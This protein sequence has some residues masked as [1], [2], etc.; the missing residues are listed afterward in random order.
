MCVCVISYQIIDQYAVYQKLMSYTD[1]SLGLVIFQACQISSQ[2]SEGYR[3]TSKCFLSFLFLLLLSP[4]IGTPVKDRFQR[5]LSSCKILV[6]S[7]SNQKIPGIDI[8]FMLEAFN[9][10]NRFFIRYNCSIIYRDFSVIG[11]PFENGSY[12]GFI[13]MIQRHEAD[14]T[15]FFIRPD[16]LVGQP[17]IIGP[18]AFPS[19]AVIVTQQ[20]NATIWN[21]RVTSFV[22]QFDD[23]VYTYTFIVLVIVAVVLTACEPLKFESLPDDR[24]KRNKILAFI[25]QFLDNLKEMH[26]SLLD[27]NTLEGSTTSSRILV[28][29]FYGFLFFLLY[30]IYLNAIG[31]DL[32]SLE[33]PG[34]IQNL[35]QLLS[36][37]TYR[38]VI[39]RGLVL[40]Q[41]LDLELKYR[42]DSDISQLYLSLMENPDESIL[43]IDMDLDKAQS[44]IKKIFHVADELE[45][46]RA[47]LIFPEFVYKAFRMYS[48]S[49]VTLTPR[50]GRALRSKETFA[51]G[52]VTSLISNNVDPNTRKVIEYFFRIVL[53]SNFLQIL[54]NLNRKVA[55]GLSGGMVDVRFNLESLKCEEGIFDDMTPKEDNWRKF[56]LRD[57]DFL[58]ACCFAGFCLAF[59]VLRLEIW[60]YNHRLRVIAERKRRREERLG[61][62]MRPATV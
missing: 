48:C 36:N 28:T 57:F 43:E 8:S 15:L 3:M 12:T 32:V 16:S 29:S 38:P 59:L 37:R 27:Q 19:D 50:T 14:T 26:F 61:K 62:K 46:S 34:R 47:A 39:I 33:I 40:Q 30:G 17:A 11:E 41:I 51:Q 6:A 10:L 56:N 45:A 35:Q 13:G 49:L 25:R 60:W 9:S 21:R 54:L 53:E 1:V 58:F 4:T 44:M 22:N 52:H 23:F 42:P 5:Q 31:A 55:L 24:R 2:F 7:Q 20:N 18:V